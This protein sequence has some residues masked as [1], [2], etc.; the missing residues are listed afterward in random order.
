M[1]ALIRRDLLLAWRNKFGLLLGPMFFVVFITI[2]V[3]AFGN[4]ASKLQSFAGPLIWIAVLLSLFLNFPIVFSEDYKD[5]SLEALVLSGES[6]L[7]IAMAKAI[8]FFATSFVPFLIIIP[9]SG[10]AFGLPANAIAAIGLSIFFSVPALI[11]YGV[12]TGALLGRQHSSGLLAVLLAAPLL[13]PVLIFGIS[14]I[15]SYPIAGMSAVE[16]RALAGINLIALAVGLPA[17]A[18]ALNANLE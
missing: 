15:N 9:L 6:R 17:T 8:S 14:A 4:D 1:N 5:G 18:A 2:C 3:I 13:I 10:I 7:L 11:I 12:L 16:F